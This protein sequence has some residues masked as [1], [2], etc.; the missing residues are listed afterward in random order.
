MKNERE[1]SGSIG[2]IILFSVICFGA[3]VVFDL[4]GIGGKVNKLLA[5]GPPD[6]PSAPAAPAPAPTA[7]PSAAIKTGDGAPA[8]TQA[9]FLDSGGYDGAV[10]ERKSTGASMII[11]FQ[12]RGC[13]ACR[14]VERELLA[15]AEM[16]RFLASVVK[17]RIDVAAG[18][19]ETRIAQHFK[20]SDLPS[21][22][23]VS[24]SGDAHLVQLQRGGGLI[25]T[26]KVIASLH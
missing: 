5:F 22:V 8:V 20:V 1:R 10:S 15:S 17:V 18:D 6:T 12:K 21:L 2:F 19:P 25:P 26:E 11:Y 14:I 9:W 7:L 3:A 4:G 13:D 23:A 16:K 24:P